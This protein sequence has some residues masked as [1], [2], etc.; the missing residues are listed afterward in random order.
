MAFLA[1]DAAIKRRIPGSCEG[2]HDESLPTWEEKKT[3]EAKIEKAVEYAAKKDGKEEEKIIYGPKP[4]VMLP[5]RSITTEPGGGQRG[6]ALFRGLRS[7]PGVISGS[8]M[9]NCWQWTILRIHAL[10]SQAPVDD[11]SEKLQTVPPGAKEWYAVYHG[12][13]YHIKGT[14]IIVVLDK[15]GH[16]ITEQ[17]DG[18][19]GS[20]VHETFSTLQPMPISGMMRHGLH[21]ID[22][23]A[24][25]AEIYFRILDKA[26]VLRQLI[27][28][29][30]SA[31]GA[32]TELARFFSSLVDPGLLTNFQK[33]A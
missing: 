1:F 25:Q 6:G 27:R 22:W 8:P 19:R 21:W 26:Q 32:S 33:V 2:N 10:T 4:D 23:F 7:I 5:L 24:K 29:R 14:D 28:L 30:Y 13:F 16:V 31:F 11:S 18:K 17:G 15:A 3:P 12:V 9:T 20:E